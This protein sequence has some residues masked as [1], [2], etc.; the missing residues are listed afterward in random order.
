MWDFFVGLQCIQEEFI[1]VQVVAFLDKSFQLTGTPHML[2]SQ[3]LQWYY[4]VKD[5]RADA[6][7]VIMDNFKGRASGTSC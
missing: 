4:F 6:A 2:K 7:V 5:S 3:K 1:K